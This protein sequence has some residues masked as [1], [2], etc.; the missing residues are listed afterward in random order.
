MSI[1]YQIF[2]KHDFKSFIC[3]V[4]Y[5]DEYLRPIAYTFFKFINLSYKEFVKI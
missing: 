2:K 3:A 4:V 1:I 5:N